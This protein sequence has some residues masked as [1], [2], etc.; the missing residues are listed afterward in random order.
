VSQHWCA[1]SDQCVRLKTH[2][3]ECAKEIFGLCGTFFCWLG[4]REKVELL[5]TRRMSVGGISIPVKKTLPPHIC[6]VISTFCLSPLTNL[7]VGE[8]DLTTDICGTWH[9][10]IFSRKEMNCVGIVTLRFWS[11]SI[12]DADAAAAGF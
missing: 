2:T 3:C 6:H 8:I 4:L 12:D 9:C 11:L 1:P 7:N 5:A 10:V